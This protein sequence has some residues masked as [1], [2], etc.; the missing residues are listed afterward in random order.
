MRI[1]FLGHLVLP[2]RLVDDWSFHYF[3]LRAGFVTCFHRFA[4]TS[5]DS[6]SIVSP[7][8]LAREIQIEVHFEG[9]IFLSLQ[10]ARKHRV[11]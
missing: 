1:G 4:V 2:Q 3:A 9:G 5:N 6:I 7:L 10:F 8:V 11:L